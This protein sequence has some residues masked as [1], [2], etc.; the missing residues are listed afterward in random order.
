MASIDTIKKTV[1]IELPALEPQIM[2]TWG[3]FYEIFKVELIY[4]KSMEEREY[5]TILATFS[6]LIVKPHEHTY[7]CM[8]KF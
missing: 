6:V 4:C 8:S 2:K 7:N 5:E 3:H 1:I